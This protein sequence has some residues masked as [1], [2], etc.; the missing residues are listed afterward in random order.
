MEMLLTVEQAASRLSLHPFTVREH[1][2]RGVLRGIKRGRQW[3]IPESAL[4]ESATFEPSQAIER[5]LDAAQDARA[6]L[7]AA[8]VGPLD[9]ASD[10]EEVRGGSD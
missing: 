6:A 8:T 10:L 9:A 2:K 3:R 5:A 1:L 7:H 4:N